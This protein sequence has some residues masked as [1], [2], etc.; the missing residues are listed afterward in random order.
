MSNG[1][2]GKVVWLSLASGVWAGGPGMRVMLEVEWMELF[3]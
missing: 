2:Q 1:N 3:P